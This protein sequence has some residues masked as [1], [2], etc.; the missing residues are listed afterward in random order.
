[1]N[2]LCSC[3]NNAMSKNFIFFDIP[4]KA[5]FLDIIILLKKFNC[6][7]NFFIFQKYIRVFF[8]YYNNK[9]ICFLK[10]ISVN[11]FKKYFSFKKICSISNNINI[12]VYSTDFG[13]GNDD[14]CF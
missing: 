14:K 1:M 13:I 8:R 3:L 12:N 11:S 7:N 2:I 6:I 10:L 4:K 9:P 5:K